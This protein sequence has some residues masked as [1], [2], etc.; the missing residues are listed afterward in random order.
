MK[1]ISNL[2]NRVISSS[3]FRTSGIYTITASI[4]AG[5][6]LLLLPVLTT[7]LSPEDYGII[8]MFQLVTSLLYPIFGMNLES[9]IARKYFDEDNSDFPS[10]VGT[11]L[12]LVCLNTIVTGT[13]YFFLF[14][15]IS[16][17]TL[18][19]FEW[20]KFTLLVA[21]CQFLSSVILTTYQVRIKPINYGFFQI[22]QSTVN[23]ILTLILVV[24]LEQSW[25]GR[26]NAQIYTGI[27]SAIISLILLYRTNQL[28]INI[29]ISD[30]KYALNFGLP[31]IPHVLGGLLFT[32]VDRF[33]LTNMVGLEQT[34]NY[35]VAYQLGAIISL[36]TL[37]FN[38]AF[39]PWLYGELNKNCEIIKLK[40]VKLTYI[41]FILISIFSIVIIYIFP[42]LVKLFVGERFTSIGVYSTFII[43]G[44][45]FQGMYYMVTNYIGYV[46]KT[47]WLAIVT[48]SVGVLKIPITYYLIKY[49]GS[50]GASISYC[51][52]FLVFF[53]LTWLLSAKV[54]KMPWL[55]FLKSTK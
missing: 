6:P 49:F 38:N 19:P 2:L 35:S 34:G 22:G 17:I 4:N 48:I 26:L 54:Y 9:S 1:F 39:T 25:K 7:K 53:I 5:I 50:S 46:N 18:I 44:F 13:L 23:I 37:A 45:V 14:Q 29:K 28:K 30:V 47:Y 20:I 11:S 16:D 42:L 52:T 21:I 3:L 12:V 10:Y 36:G 41:Y 27:L 33:F 8:A 55:F 40:I 51:I 24:V 43:W 15:Y 31:L 32:A